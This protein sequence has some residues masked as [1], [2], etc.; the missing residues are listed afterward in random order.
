[1]FRE[2]R[3]S[4]LARRGFNVVPSR[5]RILP[6]SER[7]AECVS[8]RECQAVSV[9]ALLEQDDVLVDFFPV[10]LLACLLTGMPTYP[11][12]DRPTYLPSYRLLSLS[13]ETTAARRRAGTS[14]ALR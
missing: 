10:C 4:Y 8:V 2:L 12:T 5:W 9:T 6:P 11:P 14:H 7:P 1:M 13:A 3:A